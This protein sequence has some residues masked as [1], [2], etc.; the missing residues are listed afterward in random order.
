[1]G[2][3]FTLVDNF[4]RTSRRIQAEMGRIDNATRKMAI[5][6]ETSIAGIS[7]SLGAL[8]AAFTGLSLYI[9]GARLDAQFKSY[10]LSLETFLG[11][12]EKAEQVFNRIKTDALENPLFEVD[13]MMKANTML[14]AAGTEV[15][16]S[17]RI[18]RNMSE[19]LAGL[20]R[21]NDEL[22]RMGI[23]LQ[24]IAA[25]G[26]A[27]GRDVN[28]FAY[29]G[30]DVMTLIAE[31]T[32]R[33]K[34]ELK[35]TD[36][37]LDA[38]DKAFQHATSSAGKFHNAL[39][40]AMLGPAGQWAKLLENWKFMLAELG[41]SVSGFTMMFLRNANAIVGAIRNFL[42]TGIGKAIASITSG[43]LALVAVVATVTAVIH[44]NR[45]AVIAMSYA[46]GAAT[47][48]A[49]QHAIATGRVGRAYGLLWAA[50]RKTAAAAAMTFVKF[51]P[52]IALVGGLAYV[53][54]RASAEYNAFAIGKA[55]VYG[56]GPIAFFQ[57]LGATLNWIG[58]LWGKLNY[59]TGM[60]EGI[61]AS[62]WGKI[63]DLQIEEWAKS[64]MTWLGRLKMFF[65]GFGDG[66]KETLVQIANLF[67]DNTDKYR[68][69]NDLL[70][71]GVGTLDQWR[72]AGKRFANM[73]QILAGLWV[74]NK[75]VAIASM[76][77]QI[78]VMWKFYI[79]VAAIAS[80][81]VMM[82][83]LW[84]LFTEFKEP[85]WMTKLVLG[86]QAGP[87]GRVYMASAD[88]V[89]NSPAGQQRL[90]YGLN[91]Y[92]LMPDIQ[93]GAVQ[94]GGIDMRP[95]QYKKRDADRREL[96]ARLK[97]LRETPKY[98]RPIG[99]IDR[100]EAL[101]TPA[102]S[103][104][105]QFGVRDNLTVQVILDGEVISERVIDR[106]EKKEVTQY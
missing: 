99:A 62:V 58:H 91:P 93:G 43:L 9:R 32:G 100:A 75:I 34:G 106:M 69:W 29:A 20:G 45:I 92:D 23:N 10:Q 44:L 86:A 38:L 2:I 81:L 67:T 103:G 77:A 102:E 60:F 72:E 37:T 83:D 11:S 65:K 13:A 70:V 64:V 24:Q 57:R 4:T 74:I 87:L 55:P 97:Q 35:S 25:L 7:L 52:L 73:L 71:R 41:N 95:T 27:M 59:E 78:A 89:R 15:E 30:I 48:R 5:T 76:V 28:Q 40:R 85:S 26:H 104:L 47:K 82:Y 49:V 42:G 22:A 51:A 88:A 53:I 94:W 16:K 14:I 84:K 1:M 21:G 6:L 46:Y 96:E 18:V 39:E 105:G 31:A 50:M 61:D 98:V 12:A 19:I 66:V 33:A 8:L 80:V 68:D 56:K 54:S 63:K 79:V 3:A 36:V 90:E 101:I 17:M